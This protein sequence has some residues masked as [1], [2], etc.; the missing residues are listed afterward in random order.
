MLIITV[1]VNYLP[2]YPTIYDDLI[3]I[4]IHYVRNQVIFKYTEGSNTN[5]CLT[6]S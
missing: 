2:P 6:D 4:Y 5:K 1:T 3:I